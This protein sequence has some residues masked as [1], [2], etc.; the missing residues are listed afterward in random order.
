RIPMGDGMDERNVLGP[1]QNQRQFG[2]V[3]ELV[4][5]AKSRGAKVLLGGEPRGG[6]GYFYPV[7]FLADVTDGMRVVDE[8]Q[9]GPVLPIIRYRDLED[10]IARANGTQF[11]LDASVWGS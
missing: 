4:E 5:D 3:V 6:T 11:G 1:L 7:T 8:E 2:R 10:A 9:F